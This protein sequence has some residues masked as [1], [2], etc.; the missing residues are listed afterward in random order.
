MKKIPPKVLKAAWMAGRA[1]ADR[2]QMEKMKVTERPGHWRS[3]EA[4]WKHDAG[5]REAL[6]AVGAVILAWA[7]TQETGS[8]GH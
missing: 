3:P 5:V 1:V 4:M 6:E 2:V 7:D 8:T